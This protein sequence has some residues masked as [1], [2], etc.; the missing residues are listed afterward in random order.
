MTKRCKCVVAASIFCTA[1][2]SQ[3]TIASRLDSIIEEIKLGH[4]G[5][6]QAA[7]TSVRLAI[8][9]ELQGPLPNRVSGPQTRAAGNAD[10]VILRFNEARAEYAARN[11][12]SAL[13][14]I[15]VASKALSALAGM[16]TPQQT[17][18]SDV[19]EAESKNH[20]H[21]WHQAALSAYTAGRFDNALE[22]SFKEIDMLRAGFYRFGSAGALISQRAWTLNGMIMLAKNDIPSAKTALANSALEAPTEPVHLLTPAMALAKELLGRGERKAVSTFLEECRRLTDSPRIAEWKKAVDSGQTPDFGSAARVM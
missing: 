1:L 12:A 5:T 2:W 6:A 18:D 10:E 4:Y 17:A 22:S 14:D 13:S 7:T 16:R 21:F 15:A 19:A 11:L 8:E 9:A 20:P 3:Q